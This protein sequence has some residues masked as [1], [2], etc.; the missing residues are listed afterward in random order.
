M[1]ALLHFNMAT[2]QEASSSCPTAWDCSYNLRVLQKKLVS[3]RSIQ[4][5]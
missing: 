3:F 4:N 1:K 2:K 5:M